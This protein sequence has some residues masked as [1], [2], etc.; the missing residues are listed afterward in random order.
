[1][2]RTVKNTV[3]RVLPP[4]ILRRVIEL[5][6]GRRLRSLPPQVLDTRPLR[7]LTASELDAF[8]RDDAI[9]EH[10]KG[11]IA[12]IATVFEVGDVGDAVN[13]GDRRALYHLVAALR[14]SRVLEIGTNIGGSTLALSQA[15]ST[16]AAEDAS[17]TTLDIVDVNDKASAEAAG[18]RL[19]RTPAENLELLGLSRRVTFLAQPALEFMAAT[20]QRFDFILVDGDHAAPSVYKEVA[21]AL[22]VLAPDGVVVMHDYYPEK[23]GIYSDGNIITGPFEAV[24]RLESENPTLSVL[25]LGAL[26]WET[27]LGTN[28]T[29]LALLTRR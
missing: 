25:P 21:A 15:L 2:L 5:R 20:D 7:K 27:K 26:P 23:R 1:M 28:V 16:H 8:L 22:H 10:W 17:L 4:S 14:P 3:A 13:P 12:R 18:L 11:D 24:S 9:A 29:T 19:T 6:D